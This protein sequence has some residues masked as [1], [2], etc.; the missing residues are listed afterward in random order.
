MTRLERNVNRVYTL[1]G[2][3][4]L[5]IVIMA[6]S[7]CSTGYQVSNC[8]GLAMKECCEKTVN[9]AYKYEGEYINENK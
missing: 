4:L 6:I 8:P 3:I 9:E 5:T 1:G 7:S 2:L